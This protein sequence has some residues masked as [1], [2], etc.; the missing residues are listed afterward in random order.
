MTRGIEYGDFRALAQCQ[1]REERRRRMHK[2]ANIAAIV[3]SPVA[4]L[5]LV[6]AVRAV[7]W[8]IGRLAA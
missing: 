5:G 8:I 4:L 1:R 7:A 2:R 6:Q 3:L